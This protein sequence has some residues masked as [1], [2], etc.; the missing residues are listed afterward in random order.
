[1]A[2]FSYK[3]LDL[4]NKVVEGQVAAKTKEEAGRIISKKQLSP[5][6]VRELP[7][8]RL[9]RGTIPMVDK[10]T[11]CRYIAAMLSSGLSISDGIEVLRNETKNPVMRQ[12]LGDL[13]YALEQGQP[14]SSVFEQYPNVFEPY[15][16]TLTHAGEVSGTLAD[17]FKQLEIQMRSE[18]SLTSKIKGALLYP[19]VVFTAMLGIGFMMF[20]FVL[21]QI[22]RVFLSLRVELPLFTQLLFKL[23]IALSSQVIPIVIGL[24]ASGFGFVFLLKKRS[25]RNIIFRLVSPI[26]MIKN[27]IIKIDLARFTRIFSTLLRSAVPITESLE[28]ALE[29]MSWPQFHALKDSFPEQVR[30]GKSISSVVKDSKVFPSLVV[31]MVAAGE[32]SGT[33]DS[34][35]ADLASFYEEEVEENLKSLTQ[36]LEP[37]LMLLVGV[38]VG[39]MILSI[40]API[41][42]VVSNFQQAAG[43]R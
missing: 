13:N 27:L 35:L 39:G 15:F 22:G 40:I 33:L 3:A 42:G 37:V 20:F 12:I 38:A 5:L 4:S 25:V 43:G 7:Q 16:L 8:K 10:I 2:Q 14:L 19:S 18:Y 28:I 17:V 31:Q 36:I 26:P 32:K 30:K 34:T 29:S 24:I 1:M 21:P 6:V 23:S 11:F 41:Y 9:T